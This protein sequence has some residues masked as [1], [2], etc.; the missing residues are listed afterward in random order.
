M[1]MT[2]RTYSVAGM[3]CAGCTRKISATL[4]NVAGVVAAATTLNPPEV[5][6]ETSGP[7]P[8]GVLNEALARAGAYRLSETADPVQPRQSLYP[9][10]LI[11]GYIAATV[12]LAALS[13]GD[14]SASFVMNN[15]MGGFFLVFSFFKFLDIRGFAD[16]YRS[17]DI[18][19][20]A[21]PGWGLAYPF[22]EFGL[23]VAYLLRIN[24]AVTN[25]V[26]LGLMLLGAVGV[27]PTLLDKRTIRCACLGTAIKLPMTTVTLIE[28]LGMAAMAAA[29]LAMHAR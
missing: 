16:A 2:T 10:Y 21:A 8:V 3:S 24:P 23:G 11:V 26:T 12:G 27:F 5:R 22:V 13:T 1:N 20:R 6:L 18:L 4:Q 17:Y 19:A 9:L 28:D 29:M 15:F 7:V 25:G 14:R